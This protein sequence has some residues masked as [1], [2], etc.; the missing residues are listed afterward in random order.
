LDQCNARFGLQIRG[1][2]AEKVRNE[3]KEER[4]GNESQI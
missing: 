3:E 2:F 4:I 1:E